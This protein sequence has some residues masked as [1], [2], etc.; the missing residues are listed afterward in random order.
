MMR[1]IHQKNCTLP[2]A[3]AG[4]TASM[5]NVTQITDRTTSFK[6]NFFSDIAD[7]S[8]RSWGGQDAGA[9]F[10]R[11]HSKAGRPQPSGWGRL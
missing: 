4:A 10:Y 2:I 11:V 1:K 3:A 5:V 9:S 7:S 8:H 6:E